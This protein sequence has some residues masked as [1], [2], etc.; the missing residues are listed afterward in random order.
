MVLAFASDPFSGMADEHW[1]ATLIAHR[2][3]GRWSGLSD[4][5][6][7]ELD[8]DFDALVH[9]EAKLCVA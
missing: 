1:C 2:E 7:S 9:G 6:N 8:F 5:R 4:S 3:E